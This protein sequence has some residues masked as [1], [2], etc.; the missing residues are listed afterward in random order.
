MAVNER[1]QWDINDIRYGQ[2]APSQAG[3]TNFTPGKA[4][5]RPSDENWPLDYRIPV[6]VPA[7]EESGPL[8]VE[9]VRVVKH[10]RNIVDD[11]TILAPTVI[12][13]V[14]TSVNDPANG[15][16]GTH[17]VDETE[18]PPNLAAQERRAGYDW[19]KGAT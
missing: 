14:V 16:C 13:T 19:G 3:R 18:T 4:S 2:L 10:E 1:I 11:Q 12:R 8:E 6:G 15:I 5:A 17:S 9:R 7:V